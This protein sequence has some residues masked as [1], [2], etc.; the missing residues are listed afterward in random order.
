MVSYKR[1]EGY[2]LYATLGRTRDSVLRGWRDVMIVE[3]Y[4]GGPA[5]LGLVLLSVFAWRRTRREQALA[6]ARDAMARR[7]TAEA[8]LRQAQKMDA[9]GQLTA[10]V[11]RLQQPLD[12]HRRQ[13][14][15]IGAP[16]GQGPS[17]TAAPHG[18]RDAR[19]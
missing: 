13:Y 15:A 7:E 1:V 5:V 6:Q 14:R 3:L 4:F 18:Q 16:G 8:Q 12:G 11:A 17:R 19:C 2:P 9:I 10:G